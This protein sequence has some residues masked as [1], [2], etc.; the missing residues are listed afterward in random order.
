MRLTATQPGED[1]N[2]VG[3]VGPH[4][5]QTSQ[6]IEWYAEGQERS[7]EVAGVR[8]TVRFIGRK[9]RRGRIAI[10]APPGAVFRALDLRGTVRSPDGSA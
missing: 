2:H 9:G 4:G 7:V 8:I 1:A 10:E 6:S 5:S 3:S